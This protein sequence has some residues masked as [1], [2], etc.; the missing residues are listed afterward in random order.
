MNAS[1]LGGQTIRLLMLEDNPRDAELTRRYLER[2]QLQFSLTVVDNED[3][4]R[5]MLETTV[6][7]VILSDYSMPGFDGMSALRIARRIAPEIPFVFLSG[8][9]GEERAVEALREGATDYV[10]KDR[11]SRLASAVV[12]ALTERRERNLRQSIERALRSSEQRFQTAAAATREVIIDWDLATSRIWFSDAFREDWGY[13]SGEVDAPAEWFLD[14]IHPDDRAVAKASFDEPRAHG[15]RWQCEYRLARAD[16]NYRSVIFRGMLIRDAE[17]NATRVIGAMLDVT[18]PLQLQEQLEQARRIE[19]LGRVAA[20]VAHE[21]S[22]VL[23]ALLP[24]AEV[25]QRA[26]N[27]RTVDQAAVRI[28]DAV[29]RGRR[30]TEQILR[31]SK[32]AEPALITVDL[33]R[34]LERFTPEVRSV[35]DEKIAV[36]VDAGEDPLPVAIDS[37]QMQQVLLNL[38][39]NARD[40]MPAGG[41]IRVTTEATDRTVALTVEDEGTGIPAEI[42]NKIFEPLYT[43]KRSG[44]GLGLAVAQQ[45]V[46]RHGGSIDATSVVGKGTTFRI[47]LPRAEE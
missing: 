15:E 27:E 18:E 37:A 38:V 34:W 46:V 47:L 40:A 31:F 17:G 8:S 28:R 12:R 5:T 43:T 35:A 20:T 41:T 26:P 42:L 3:A 30:L 29:A 44:T 7:D 9:I 6:P 4:F 14:R 2:E 10:L 13:E 24:L 36:D 39:V 32:P 21:F 1:N 23:M 19:S 16:G 45:I 11:A 33:G 22:N 25:L